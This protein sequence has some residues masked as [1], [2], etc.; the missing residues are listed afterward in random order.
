MCKHSLTSP[1]LQEAM[2]TQALYETSLYK[3]LLSVESSLNCS[4]EQ[5]GAF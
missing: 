1:G 5:I 2:H 4:L 3:S